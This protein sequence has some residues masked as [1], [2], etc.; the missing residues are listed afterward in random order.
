[1]I[2]IKLEH[3]KFFGKKL[4]QIMGKKKGF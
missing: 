4:R 3:L 2:Y 1:M